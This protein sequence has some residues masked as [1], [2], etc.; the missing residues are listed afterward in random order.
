MLCGFMSLEF[1]FR[2]E[3]KTQNETAETTTFCIVSTKNHNSAQV[4]SKFCPSTPNI[5]EAWVKVSIYLILDS[6][7]A[8]VPWH[9]DLRLVWSQTVGDADCSLLWL[10]AET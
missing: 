4:C 3:P 7:E 9:S 1:P 8:F 2:T 10:L 6:L 5:R